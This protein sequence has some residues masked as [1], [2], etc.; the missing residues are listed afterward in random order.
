MKNKKIK[1]VKRNKKK[2]FFKNIIYFIY[3]SKIYIYI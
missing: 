3:I 1:I 2:S